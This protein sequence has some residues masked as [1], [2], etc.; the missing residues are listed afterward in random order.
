MENDTAINEI[1]SQLFEIE[2]HRKFIDGQDK[3]SM[4]YLGSVKTFA[5]QMIERSVKILMIINE[6]AKEH[7]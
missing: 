4:E 1:T 2:M 5:K 3:S 6:N 7:E